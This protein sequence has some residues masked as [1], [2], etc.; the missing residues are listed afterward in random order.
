VSGDSGH[1]NA[2]LV[3][4]SEV[5]RLR[6]ELEQARKERDAWLATFQAAETLTQRYLDALER[7][8]SGDLTELEM[9]K[10][11]RDAVARKEHV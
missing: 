2:P 10:V 6:A 7:I 8:G 11:A 4:D 3:S 1:I 5:V 9:L